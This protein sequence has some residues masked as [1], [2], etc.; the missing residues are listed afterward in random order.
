[1]AR[2]LFATTLYSLA[3]ENYSAARTDSAVQEC[4]RI[5]AALGNWN[6]D[7][8]L[9]IDLDNLAEKIVVDNLEAHPCIAVV[10]VLLAVCL[11]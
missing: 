3:A 5:L 9:R 6:R 4:M 2:N 7:S 10:R 8:D 1:M 11:L